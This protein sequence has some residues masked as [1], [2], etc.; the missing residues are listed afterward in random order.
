MRK[1]GFRAGLRPLAAAAVALA[2]FLGTL[3][4]RPYLGRA[5]RSRLEAG[6]ARRGLSMRI[7][8]V[9][10]GL[11]PPLRLTGVA[12][13][14][15][16]GRRLSADAAEAWWPGR[17]RLEVRQAVLRGPAGLTVGAESTTWDVVGSLRDDFKLTL[18]RPESGLVLGRTV[19]PQES[20]WAVEAT[21][22]PA[23][24]LLDVRQLDRPLLDLG[25]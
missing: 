12:L 1:T 13:E 22:L 21:D 20:T 2:L 25:I 24:R 10:V 15:G 11:W 19:S 3:A 23:D 6:A 8:G 17:I 5:V 7:D 16:G 4:L 18:V 9:R 14:K